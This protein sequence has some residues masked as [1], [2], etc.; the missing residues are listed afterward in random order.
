MRSKLYK[1]YREGMQ[2]EIQ[3][4][5]EVISVERE[6]VKQMN[7]AKL[8]ESKQLISI[9]PK[10]LTDDVLLKVFSSNDLQDL[11]T[12]KLEVTPMM[13]NRR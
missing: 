4:R 1:V 8:E 11:K 13:F 12:Q 5:K 10:H 9:A 2:L 6:K 7:D 3:K